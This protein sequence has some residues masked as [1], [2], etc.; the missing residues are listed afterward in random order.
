M[1]DSQQN[2]KDARNEYWGKVSFIS[3]FANLLGKNFFSTP[4]SKMIERHFPERG[5]S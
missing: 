5:F 2:S 3:F 1:N 4:T